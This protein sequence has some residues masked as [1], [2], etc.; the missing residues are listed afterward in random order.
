MKCP[1]VNRQY[2]EEEPVY[3]PI[4]RPIFDWSEVEEHFPHAPPKMDYS[5][6]TQV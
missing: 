5:L 2:S 4:I 6:L 1:G 3:P